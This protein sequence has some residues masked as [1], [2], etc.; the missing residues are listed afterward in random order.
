MLVHVRTLVKTYLMLLNKY[1]E[2]Q[3]SQDLVQVPVLEVPVKSLSAQ[4]GSKFPTVPALLVILLLLL[5]AAGYLYYQNQQLKTM[6]ASYQ[7]TPTPLV[8]P[9]PTAQ[10]DDPTA[11]WKTYTNLKYGY[12]IKYPL[13]FSTEQIVAESQSEA[14]TISRSFFVFQTGSSSPYEERYINFEFTDIE[15]SYDQ[16]TV[17]QT[18]L[19]G[20][21]VKKVVLP[22][23]SFD[24]Y[25]I[26]NSEGNF[27]EVYVSNNSTRSA[28]ANQ[29][30]STFK[31]LDTLLCG[32]IKGVK[33][34]SG[35]SCNLPA[36][37]PDANGTCTKD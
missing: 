12:S 24:I 28:I 31:F 34:P 25:S 26:K 29:I 27:I 10:A 23:M 35:Y 1:M 8:S 15:P 19:N 17:T 7:P 21:S 30:L 36:T 4:A 14:N 32:G 20:Y 3:A 2:K 11:N 22:N 9:K 16:G 18:I 33:C 6:L 5:S 37:Y 13:G